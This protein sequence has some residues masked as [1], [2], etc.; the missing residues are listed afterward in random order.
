MTTKRRTLKTYGERGRSARVFLERGG[1]MIR[2]QWRVH[3][4]LKTQSFPNSPQGKQNAKDYAQGVADALEARSVPTR[5]TVAELW[6]R[7]AE[8][9]LTN[10]RPR[11]FALNADAWRKWELFVGRET[12]AEDLGVDSMAGLRAELERKFNLGVNTI[13]RVIRGVKV[14]Y[15][16]GEAHEL[17]ARNK[18]HRYRFKVGKDR[19]P[20]KVAEY[21]KEDFLALCQALPL[22]GRNWRAGGIVRLCG[23]QGV[24]Q[25]AVRHLQ[26]SDVDF[27]GRSITW[28]SRWDKLGRKWKQPL[29]EATAQVLQTLALKNVA[30]LEWVFPAPR[31]RKSGDP[32][33]SAQALWWAL[34]E[35]EKRAGI[36]HLPNR[37]AHGL[38]RMLAGDVMALTGNLKTAGDAI[39]DKDLRILQEHYLNDRPEEVRAAFERLDTE[40]V[41]ET[42]I[43][44][45][46]RQTEDM[47]TVWGNDLQSEGGGTRTH[48][49]TP[50]GNTEPTPVAGKSA[51]HRTGKPADSAPKPGRNRNPNR[52]RAVTRTRGS[53]DE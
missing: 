25:G 32:V 47:R 51:G 36:D 24:R 14:V 46:E 26:W 9:E 18:L 23:Y 38:R 12:V 53:G 13:A 34:T 41:T 43:A 5:L 48:D 2:V 49:L 20:G 1:K 35:A 11:T 50:Q 6:G 37:G 40:T 28:Q 31:Q 39:G 27:V 8:S 3:G 44:E 29:R 33:Y 52:N 15:N 30:G 7:Y 22:D 17:L 16:W 10:L 19:K 42:A 4:Q 21:R 45:A